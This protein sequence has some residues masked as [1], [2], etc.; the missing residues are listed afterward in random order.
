MVAQSPTYKLDQDS[1]RGDHVDAEWYYS[2]SIPSFSDSVIE[3][4][5]R[6]EKLLANKTKFFFFMAAHLVTVSLLNELAMRNKHNM[7]IVGNI[8]SPLHTIQRSVVP[9]VWLLSGVLYVASKRIKSEVH[10]QIVWSLFG[11]LM[12]TAVSVN[13]VVWKLN[14]DPG[15]AVLLKHL[16]ASNP[17]SLFY[18]SELGWF[19]TVLLIFFTLLIRPRFPFCAW[20]TGFSFLLFL[21]SARMISQGLVVQNLIL[22]VVVYIFC[23]AFN[24]VTSW[25]MEQS[26]R[27]AWFLMRDLE[28]KL[29]AEKKKLLIEAEAKFEAERVLVAYLCHEI[30][31]L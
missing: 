6:N 17:I 10:H 2:V 8:S 13:V 25:V 23:C 21:T 11:V 12:L 20:I 28:R 5:Y 30:R 9:T 26:E 19:L 18:L 4:N 31:K 15:I 22:R 1:A 7:S 3:A 24:L 29:A 16:T 14:Y 27:K